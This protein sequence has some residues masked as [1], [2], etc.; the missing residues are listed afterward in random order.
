VS[1]FADAPLLGGGLSSEDLED[2]SEQGE[3]AGGEDFF[4]RFMV[5]RTLRDNSCD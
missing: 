1:D 4:N 3:A 5:R 2:S